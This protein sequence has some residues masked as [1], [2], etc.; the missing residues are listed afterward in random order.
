MQ[1]VAI[2][3]NR[4]QVVGAVEFKP[5]AAALSSLAHQ[6]GGVFQHRSRRDFFELQRRQAAL[7]V[8]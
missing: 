2:G 8:R 7:E 3:A 5:D 4:R 6:L 1:L